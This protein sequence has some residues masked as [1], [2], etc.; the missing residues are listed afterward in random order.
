MTRVARLYDW[1]ESFDNDHAGFFES[2]RLLVYNEPYDAADVRANLIIAG[3][4]YG[5][6]K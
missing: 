1:R 5:N 4:C 6:I 3:K 2:N